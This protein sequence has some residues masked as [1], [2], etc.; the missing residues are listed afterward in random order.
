MSATETAGSETLSRREIVSIMSGLMLAQF[1]GALDQT[2]VAPAM[3]TLGRTLG[4]VETLPWVVTAYLLVSTAVTPLYG[5]L[6]D[7]HG[8]RPIL[9]LSIGLFILGSVACALAPTMLALAL[10]RGF[11]GLGGGGLI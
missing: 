1:M 4:D 10:A 6:A 9:L 3:P 11:Q 8:R 5:K 7:I 2:I